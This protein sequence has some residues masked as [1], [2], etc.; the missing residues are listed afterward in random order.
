MISSPKFHLLSAPFVNRFDD[1][2]NIIPLEFL[3]GNTNIIKRSSESRCAF[4][5]EIMFH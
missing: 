2:E 1:S 5:K 3:Y 4:K